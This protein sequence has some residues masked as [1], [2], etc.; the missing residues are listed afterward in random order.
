VATSA[1]RFYEAKGL[2]HADRT[3]AGH[4]RYLRSALRRIAFIV[5]AQRV[6]LTLDEV[7]AELAKLPQNRV[8][9]AADWSRLAGGWS[10]RIDA[11]IAELQRL[12]AGLTGCIGCGC[13]S[14]ETCA[15]ANPG[16]RAA[17]RGRARRRGAACP[18]ALTFRSTVSPG[19]SCVQTSAP[20]AARP[21]RCGLLV[22]AG[23]ARRRAA[24]VDGARFAGPL[25]VSIVGTNDLH[26]GVVARNGRGSLA[27]L[28][29]YEEPARG[30]ARDGG[31]V[32][33]I[34]AGD[35]FQGTLESNIGEGAAVVAAYNALGYRRGD[36]QPRVRLRA[37]RQ[38]GDAA[39]RATIPAVRCGRGGGGALPLPR[40]EPDRYRERAR[41]PN[42][43]TCGDHDGRRGRHQGR[44]R[45]RD[46]AGGPDRDHRRQR[47]RAVGGAAARHDPDARDRAAVPGRQRRHRRRPRRR[48]LHRGR[49]PSTTCRP[50]TRTP[51][52][53]PSPA[54]CR[55]AG[56]R[57]RGRP[58]APAMAHQVEGI[59]ITE[60]YSTDAPSDAST[61]ASIAGR[62]PSSAGAAF[63]RATCA[64]ARPVTKACGPR[65]DA[66]LVPVE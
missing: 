18:P 20:L 36:R 56:R 32:L 60:A 16:D 34:D 21:R 7:A 65:S 45:R 19:G 12:K 24:A 51:R 5:F 17:R 59:A 58:H 25:T 53:W 9:D 26:G 49:S 40:R 23:C 33:L 64:S 29:G 61:S 15:L 14:L 66:A 57:H 10:A 46:D 4:R 3:E 27:L 48:T 28:G 37:G 2:I 6:G 44:H 35:M 31:A 1:L 50:A 52:S 30:P 13:L 38:G 22:I 55:R 43:P 8:P 39:H 63:R 42:G 41:R 62:G 47:R 54:G 11:R